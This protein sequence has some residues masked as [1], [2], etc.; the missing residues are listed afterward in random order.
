MPFFTY[1]EFKKFIAFEDDILYKTMYDT[2]YYCGLRKGE[3]R[4]LT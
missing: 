2:L 1:N 4:A 3:V